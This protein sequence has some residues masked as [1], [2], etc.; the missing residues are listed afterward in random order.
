MSDDAP[1]SIVFTSV[2]IDWDPKP[3]TPDTSF[4]VY[5]QERNDGGQS[6]EYTDSVVVKDSLG[7]EWN[8]DL[9]CSPLAPGA[10]E[11]RS[12]EV[13][14]G[15]R[16]G[17]SATVDV[18]LAYELHKFDGSGAHHRA[19]QIAQL[20]AAHAEPSQAA[21]Q[22][23]AAAP[24][25]ARPY[26]GHP[27]RLHATGDPVEHWQQRLSEL[28]YKVE[29]DGKFG[30]GT[31]LASRQFQTDKGLPVDGVVGPGTWEAAWS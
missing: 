18:F 10:M 7:N 19:A 22:K 4:T 13:R 24:V 15:L 5:W 27:L 23:P 30:H 28:G 25:A 1:P 6:E 21:A 3:L 12:M 9:P 31:E 8:H 11:M 14:G 29:V 20:H 16:P 26:P 17:S 2:P